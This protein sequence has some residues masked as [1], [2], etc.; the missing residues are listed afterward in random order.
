MV[1]WYPM[2]FKIDL[3]LTEDAAQ[4]FSENVG[5]LVPYAEFAPVVTPRPKAGKGASMSYRAR[6]LWYN[7]KNDMQE[8]KRRLVNK[9]TG[10]PIMHD[11]AIRV[12]RGFE[13]LSQCMK[14]YQTIAD[15]LEKE[16]ISPVEYAV[17]DGNFIR[18]SKKE[19][20]FLNK[21][22]AVTRWS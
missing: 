8:S 3:Y 5:A 22:K 4:R 16:G 7:F 12:V 20:R 19:G 11:Y 9:L 2:G 18:H 14:D 6:I 17:M 10:E 21:L 13:T 1:P 15:V